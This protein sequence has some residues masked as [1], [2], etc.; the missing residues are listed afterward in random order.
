MHQHI[1]PR[2]HGAFG[3][4][5]AVQGETNGTGNPFRSGGVV[6]GIAFETELPGLWNISW[7]LSSRP[8]PSLP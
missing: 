2:G 7:K 1:W 8:L 5:Y 6:G 3:A 4:A